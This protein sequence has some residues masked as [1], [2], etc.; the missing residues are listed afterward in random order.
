MACPVCFGG[1]DPGM[2]ES[3]TAGI[4]VLVGVTMV[5]LTALASFFVVLARRARRVSLDP[6]VPA[7]DPQGEASP[8]LRVGRQ[9]AG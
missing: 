9:E 4:G 6:P 5:V 1:E 8:G 7:A 2:R 3:L